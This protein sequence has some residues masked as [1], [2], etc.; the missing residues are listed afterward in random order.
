MTVALLKLPTQKLSLRIR[1]MREPNSSFL[2][3][4]AITNSTAREI[5]ILAGWRNLSGLGVLSRD[6]RGL[7]RSSRRLLVTYMPTI[8]NRSTD[9]HHHHDGQQYCTHI[10]V[11]DVNNIDHL[12]KG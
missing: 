7:C 9:G 11:N 5:Y 1:Q 3:C 8:G 2:Q 6:T 4:S 12:V 10:P